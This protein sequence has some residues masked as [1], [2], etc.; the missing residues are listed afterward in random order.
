MSPRQHAT[1]PAHA[2]ERKH[3]MTTYARTFWLVAQF[4]IAHDDFIYRFIESD[5]K[6][7]VS[8]YAILDAPICVP[9]DRSLRDVLGD[10]PVSKLGSYD[11]YDTVNSMAD[12]DAREGRR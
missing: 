3:A 4:R 6:P 12:A 5:L 2:L 9:S 7:V 8:G 1:A 11:R 10:I